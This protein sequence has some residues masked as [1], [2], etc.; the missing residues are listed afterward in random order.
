MKYT[1]YNFASTR[2][3]FF[4]YKDNFQENIKRL[5]FGIFYFAFLV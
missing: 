3:V 2:T 5:F 4:L 1:L